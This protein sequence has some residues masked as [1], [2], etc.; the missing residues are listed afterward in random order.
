[1]DEERDK[2]AEDEFADLLEK[3]D[4]NG[5]TVTKAF[6]KGYET[7]RDIYQDKPDSQETT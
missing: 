7:A 6:A 4:K 3:M 5:V 1:M 2:K